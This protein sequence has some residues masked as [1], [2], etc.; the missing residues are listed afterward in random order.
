MI[1]VVDIFKSN[2]VNDLQIKDKELSSTNYLDLCYS[3][4]EPFIMGDF[5]G[6]GDSLLFW[7]NIYQYMVTI[8]DTLVNQFSSGPVDVKVV[9]MNESLPLHTNLKYHKYRQLIYIIW[10]IFV[11]LLQMTFSI[12]IKQTVRC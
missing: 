10:Y 11:Y 7:D 2:G 5:N 1:S 9:K 3:Y 4:K 6:L 12:S 8:Y